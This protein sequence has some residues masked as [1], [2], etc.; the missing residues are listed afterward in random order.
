MHL[1]SWRAGFAH[2]IHPIKIGYDGNYPKFFQ[3]L[4][5]FYITVQ[6]TNKKRPLASFQRE[7]ESHRPFSHK[8]LGSMTATLR[9]MVFQ[10]YKLFITTYYFVVS[11]CGSTCKLWLNLNWTSWKSRSEVR[12]RDSPLLC[13]VSSHLY[14]CHLFAGFSALRKDITNRLCRRGRRDWW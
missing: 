3:F 4:S 1:R 8:S 12:S 6:H 14:I 11:V 7:K 13:L 10:W 9:Y 2:Q 5:L